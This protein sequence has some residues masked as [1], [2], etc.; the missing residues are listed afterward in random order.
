MSTH[1]CVHCSKPAPGDTWSV[2]WGL[3]YHT[4]LVCSAA[5]AR[6]FAGEVGKEYLESD[7]E[8]TTPEEAG[9]A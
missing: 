2:G 6:A 7:V 5:C 9:A 1:A 8:W 3:M 4:I